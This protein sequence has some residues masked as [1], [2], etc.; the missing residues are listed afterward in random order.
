MLLNLPSPL[1]VPL[2]PGISHSRHS[3]MQKG[4]KRRETQK[5]R[6]QCQRHGE[7]PEHAASSG[8]VMGGE[9]ATGSYCICTLKGSLRHQCASNKMF[10]R[11]RVWNIIS[12]GEITGPSTE[13]LITYHVYS[14]VH[15]Y[16]GFSVGDCPNVCPSCTIH[17]DDIIRQQ[18]GLGQ[19]LVF[20]H[21]LMAFL[22]FMLAQRILRLQR[23]L[24]KDGLSPASFSF[25]T[26]CMMEKIEVWT[27]YFKG[28]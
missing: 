9:R 26:N 11:R 20:A 6:N 15:D 16:K 7:G 10:V 5:R 14:Q 4:V 13:S 18:R 21:H 12:R 3:H 17:H 25:L 2:S 19:T 28:T 22:T 27:L 1:L 23:N 24:R 8:L